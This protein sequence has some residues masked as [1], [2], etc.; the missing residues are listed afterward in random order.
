MCETGRSRQQGGRCRSAPS[1]GRKPKH[2]VGCFVLLGD[3]DEAQEL[4]RYFLE[5]GWRVAWHSG[6]ASHHT[7][8]SRVGGSP[9]LHPLQIPSVYS[10]ARVMRRSC[11]LNILQPKALDGLGW[12]ISL[13]RACDTCQGC[14]TKSGRLALSSAQE[15][16][17][18]RQHGQLLLCWSCPTCG[19]EVAEETTPLTSLSQAK[20]IDV[21]R[22]CSKCR[23]A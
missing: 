20:E 16:E 7:K 4:Q 15:I 5:R 3:G 12:P 18:K 9:N 17:V 2:L 23:T 6:S 21:D 10:R 22:L 1:M 11:W 14:E 8:Q 19:R 13:T